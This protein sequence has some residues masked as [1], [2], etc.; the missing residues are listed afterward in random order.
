MN[1]LLDCP[2]CGSNA[3]FTP[4]PKKKIGEYDLDMGRVECVT[5]DARTGTGSRDLAIKA[6]N[7]RAPK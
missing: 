6:W 3:I 7:R 1:G 2:F 5:C 4:T